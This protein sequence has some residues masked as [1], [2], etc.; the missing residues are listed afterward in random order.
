MR[1]VK[2][3]IYPYPKNPKLS[4]KLERYNGS[5]SHAW[6]LG[7]VRAQQNLSSEFFFG[8]EHQ[9]SSDPANSNGFSA[10]GLE[11]RKFDT[12]ENEIEHHENST[13]NTRTR[14]KNATYWIATSCENKG[15]HIYEQQNIGFIKAAKR[16]DGPMPWQLAK[17]TA[18]IGV[19]VCLYDFY[20]LPQY[21][22][23]G[24]STVLAYNALYEYARNMATALYVSATSKNMRELAERYGYKASG[25]LGDYDLPTSQAT[26][27]KYE[28]KNVA[29]VLR[30]MRTDNPW[31]TQGHELTRSN[32]LA[33]KR[34]AQDSS[35][36]HQFA[37]GFR[38]SVGR[39]GSGQAGSQGLQTQG[40]NYQ[41]R[42]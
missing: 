6:N 14:E 23:T 34:M 7:M 27:I 26:V 38:L 5:N 22:R 18:N 32:M 8:N 29:G 12:G 21:H 15:A 16:A 31:L 11:R 4:I 37:P 28:A 17:I 39:Q 24:L 42:V 30:R 41:A 36:T 13:V 1:N 2:S 40:S 9:Q 35:R 25:E 33:I 20:I 10:E 3:I 19:Y